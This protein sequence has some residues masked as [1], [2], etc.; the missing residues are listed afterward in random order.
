VAAGQ[1]L[2]YTVSLVDAYDFSI[3]GHYEIRYA[4]AVPHGSVTFSSNVLALSI[5]GRPMFEASESLKDNKSFVAITGCGASRAQ[6][7]QSAFTYAKAYTNEAKTYVTN[8]PTKTDRWTRWFG[9]FNT[10]RWNTV[11]NGYTKIL[12]T[13]NQQE[14]QVLCDCNEQWNGYVVPS[15]PYKIHV[16]QGFWNEPTFG[17]QSKAGTL[18]HETSHFTAVIGSLD[19]QAEPIKSAYRYTWFAVDK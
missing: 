4:S 2:T 16:C 8:N 7:I 13:L 15:Q 11:K 6:L 10:S 5:E 3:S 18:I 14:V 9:D 19:S 12:S 1:H 17:H